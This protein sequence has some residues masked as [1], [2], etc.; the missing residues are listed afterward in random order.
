MLQIP[1]GMHPVNCQHSGGN[2]FNVV[3]SHAFEQWVRLGGFGDL[4]EDDLE[5]LHQILKSIPDRTSHPAADS[6]QA[7]VLGSADLEVD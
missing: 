6:H 3:L 2:A 5:H 1:I 4:L 7:V